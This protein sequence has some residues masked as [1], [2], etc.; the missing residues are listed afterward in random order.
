MESYFQYWGKAKKDSQASGPDYH[1]LPY[2][3]LDVAAVG[4]LLLDP[5]KPLC[6]Q[7]AGRLKV[8]S[9]WLRDWFC[10]C[11]MLHDIGKFFRAFQN[12]APNLSPLL[13]SFEIGCIYNTRHDT[14]GFA[15]W[16]HCLRK[17]LVQIIPSEYASI[18][19]GWLEIVCGHHGKPPENLRVIKPYLME[20]DELAAEQYVVDVAEE[21][22][23]D[24][25]PLKAM[26]KKNFNR[27]SW[28]LAGIAVLSDW[29]GS[30]Q[31]IFQYCVEPMPLKDYWVNVALLKAVDA[32]QLA[33]I[34]ERAV[35]PFR[36]I[37]QQFNF[38]K[39]PTPLQLYAQTVEFDQSPQL[40]IL[41]DVTGAGKTE[42]AM[43]LVH[44]LMAAGLANGLYVGLPTM[45]TANAMY[46]RM[47]ESYRGLYVGQQL[48]SLV[49]AHGASQL[50]QS[51][52]DS[53]V[54]SKQLDDKNYEPNELSASAYCNYWL[55]DSRKKALLA[56]VGV[57]TIDQ[58]LLGVLPARHQS[59]RLLGLTNKV[60]LVDE[61]HAFD[62][63]MRSL[64]AALLQAHAAQGGS[65][66]LLSATLPYSFRCELSNAFAR[67]CALP[68]PTLHETAK[69]P[70]VTQLNAENFLE[71]PIA[72]RK[73]VERRVVVQ[74][75]GNETEA[76]SL[77]KQTVEQGQ[78]VCWI[79]N[80]VNDARN[81]YQQLQNQIWVDSE[82]LTL[83]HSRYTMIDRQS[84]E[85]DVLQRFG[86]TS[87]SAERTGQILIAT[88][89]VEQSLDL[90]FDV[91]ISDL[92]PVDLLIQR[93]GRLQRH[94]RTAKGEPLVDEDVK[95]QRDLPCFWLLA[96][97]PAQVIDGQWLRELLPGTQ[98]VYPNV[99]QLWL[100][101]KALLKN[102][103]FGMPQDARDLIEGVYGKTAQSQIP[104][105]LEAASNDALAKQRAESGMGSFNL[106]K[107]EKGY[108]QNSASHNGGWSEEVNIPTRLSGDTVTCV[109]VRQL[110]GEWVAYAGNVPHRWALSQLSLP[111]K[112]WEQVSRLISKDL[113]KS[114]EQLKLREPALRWLE[115]MPLT[116]NTIYPYDSKGG[117]FFEK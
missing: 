80:T 89:V 106:L 79:R 43:V 61:V 44:R 58:A 107:L 96:P 71:A 47:A 26:D 104:S 50:S 99:G 19:E 105:A 8:D 76:F 16:A 23:P 57:G 90:D 93:A 117:W 39:N 66:I 94:I 21:W 10:F 70:W 11:L 111:K 97:D 3:C 45:A 85:A 20:S 38:I 88:Q 49:L 60:L 35:N 56:D 102:N 30:N 37:S 40:F 74:R 109:L 72:T 101:V 112:E 12:L 41:E 65:V 100:T 83:F 54:L 95:D 82:N 53:V 6:Q 84:L 1:L 15:L 114:L 55:A 103:G 115:L 18:F 86:K 64:L 32:I 27:I 48:P 78:C 116:G 62:P 75:L 28:Q 29:L 13:V 113:Q 31:K 9:S 4:Y 77:I 42:A 7:L 108:T 52:S 25:A 24:L 67:G 92:A 51:F 34:A 46:K 22:L 87:Q 68:A 73:S 14:L 91:M 59:L 63:Y 5:K 110:D 98:A 33:N 17:K 69:Y 2:H 81:A 36:S